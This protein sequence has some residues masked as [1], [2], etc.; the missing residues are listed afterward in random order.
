MAVVHRAPYDKLFLAR[1]RLFL[2]LDNLIYFRYDPF[3]LI[4]V[5]QV[6]KPTVLSRG[7]FVHAYAVNMAQANNRRVVVELRDVKC[8]TYIIQQPKD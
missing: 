2:R 8:Y 7:L 4:L 6:F 5:S 1:F 3:C